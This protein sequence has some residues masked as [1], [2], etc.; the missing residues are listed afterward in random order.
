MWFQQDMHE[1]FVRLT[2]LQL[3]CFAQA[4]TGA[5]RTKRLPNGLKKLCW[6]AAPLS[7]APCA[8]AEAA[9]D[10]C[11]VEW[12]TADINSYTM[13]FCMPRPAGVQ[14][15]TSIALHDRDI[16]QLLLPFREFRETFGT[17]CTS[18]LTAIV[19]PRVDSDH[20]VIS[21][22]P[23]KRPVSSPTLCLQSTCARR[24]SSITRHS[25]INAVR[26]RRTWRAHS[27]KHE[28]ALL[29]TPCCRRRVLRPPPGLRKLSQGIHAP[30]L[31]QA[32]PGLETVRD[33]I[34]ASGDVHRFGNSKFLSIYLQRAY[35]PP[36]RQGLFPLAEAGDPA[37]IEPSEQVPYSSSMI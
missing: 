3:L 36:G 13:Q 37:G 9:S 7:S 12:E 35:L 20:P 5:I 23:Q 15:L 11:S 18:V 27:A 29:C 2:L 4:W 10:L 16:F 24:R 25:I 17:A 28:G 26:A 21:V 34:Q 32:G 30:S 6:V 1:N 22:R 14:G 33:I 19:V 8:F 31:L